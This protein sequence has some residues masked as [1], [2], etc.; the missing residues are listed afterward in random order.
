MAGASSHIGTA[1]E[2][3]AAV[4]ERCGSLQA[5][6]SD[7]LS[8]VR[9]RVDLVSSQ[10]EH[11]EQQVTDSKGAVQVAAL[12]L[13]GKLRAALRSKFEALDAKLQP[14]VATR[15]SIRAKIVGAAKAKVDEL[16]VL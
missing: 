2:L 5:S 15:R 1:G 3:E 12:V 7:S 13:G 4:S 11:V 16:E 6:L 8:P 9:S 14:Q 10:V